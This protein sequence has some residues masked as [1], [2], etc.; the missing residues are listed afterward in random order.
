MRGP[1]V[2]GIS[3]GYTVVEGTPEPPGSQFVNSAEDVRRPGVGVADF[4]L[5]SGFQS[6]RT[7][8]E[9]RGEVGLGMGVARGRREV[10]EG[11]EE[12]AAER[13]VRTEG[14]WEREGWMRP[15]VTFRAPSSPLA[16]PPPPLCTP[17]HVSRANT[18]R[19]AVPSF[20]FSS[21]RVRVW[22]PGG[23]FRWPALGAETGAAACGV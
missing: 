3:S 19:N 5:M 6:T 21:I 11:K 10:A 2:P 20:P 16:R 9:D 18:A 8:G 13:G 1:G 12:R 7:L 22:S 4:I 14:G 15:L 17:P 23:S